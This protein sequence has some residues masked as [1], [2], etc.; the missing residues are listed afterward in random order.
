M[1]APAPRRAGRRSVTAGLLLGLS[2]VT[3]AAAQNRS[4]PM[5]PPDVVARADA[6]DLL[7]APR[8]LTT[9]TRITP[10]S[11]SAVARKTRLAKGSSAWAGLATAL[12]SAD[13]AAGGEA[14]EVRLGVVLYDGDRTLA[15]LFLQPASAARDG[16]VFAVVNGQA[17]SA[18]AALAQALEALGG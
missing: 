11:L 9:R 10:D 16:R 14:R 2:G 4:R 5:L 3:G 12:A 18:S 8:D 1:S 7:I 6:A 17:S 15:S 13:F